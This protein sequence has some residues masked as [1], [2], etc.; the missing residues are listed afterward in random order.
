MTKVQ[1]RIVLGC[2][3][4]FSVLGLLWFDHG[5]ANHPL[6]SAFV[7]GVLVA[8]YAEFMRLVARAGY[9]P[10][11][12]WGFLLLSLALAGGLAPGWVFRAG[13]MPPLALA[14]AVAMALIVRA[15]ARPM[16]R[17]TMDDLGIT[18][19]GVAYI[20]VLG[21]VCLPLRDLSEVGELG[22][23]GAIVVSKGGDVLAYFCGR[24]WG[25]TKLA[26][27]ISPG[28]TILGSACGLV[29]AMAIWMG[30]VWA[31]GLAPR[32]PWWFQVVSGIMIA[33]AAQLGDLAESVFK[34]SL[35]VKD[36]AALLPEFGGVLD[37]IDAV[38]FAVPVT[39]LCLEGGRLLEV[40]R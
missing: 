2:I 38:L 23:W 11:A 39:Y 5:R 22:L 40:W 14:A 27:R 31:F 1:T 34:R 30:L 3:V 37:I 15:F 6:T 28:K 4:G 24:A 32:L 17:Q 19:L 35:A 16:A 25:Q 18:F 29:G 36:S 13:P 10:L 12:G 21:G 9:R 7:L 20:G 8:G 26:P 33:G